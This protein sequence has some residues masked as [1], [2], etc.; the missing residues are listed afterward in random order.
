VGDGRKDGGAA[1]NRCVTIRV[2]ASVRT[3]EALMCTV[4]DTNRRMTVTKPFDNEYWYR[5]AT[6]E[7]LVHDTFMKAI[8]VMRL[9]I[10]AMAIE[11]AKANA[12]W[13]DDPTSEGHADFH[14]PPEAQFPIG[15]RDAL[16]MELIEYYCTNEPRKEV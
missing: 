15:E 5:V 6:N 11:H 16:L 9:S 1:Q 2:T 10:D 7:K 8:R 13:H 14:A 3:T 4:S 12:M